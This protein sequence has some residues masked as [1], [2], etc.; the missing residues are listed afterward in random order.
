MELC[1]RDKLFQRDSKRFRLN[2]TN[3]ACQK[4][5]SWLC[6]LLPQNQ[7]PRI[8]INHRNQRV[9]PTAACLK[10]GVFDCRCIDGQNMTRHWFDE[11]LVFQSKSESLIRACQWCGI[12][13]CSSPRKDKERN[14]ELWKHSLLEMLKLHDL[15]VLHIHSIHSLLL[16]L[17][18]YIHGWR[19]FVCVSWNF[20]RY[21]TIPTVCVCGRLTFYIS[22]YHPTPP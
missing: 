5:L 4:R 9:S 10:P 13:G 8:L 15:H 16:I 11:S 20:Q 3:I 2:T 6:C 14:K 17:Y 22:C 12:A 21:S 1:H 7:I 19:G 18:W